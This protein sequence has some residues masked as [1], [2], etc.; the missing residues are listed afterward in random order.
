MKDSRKVEGELENILHYGS[1]DPEELGKLLATIPHRTIQQKFMRV[2]KAFMDEQDRNYVAGNF[3]ARNEATGMYC[4]AINSL[5]AEYLSEEIGV[6]P[7][8]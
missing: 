7:F 2:V 3:D 8:I 6:F 1:Y 4:A 5:A